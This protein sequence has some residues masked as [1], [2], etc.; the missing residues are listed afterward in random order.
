MRPD[1]TRRHLPRADVLVVKAGRPELLRFHDEEYDL[2]MLDGHSSLDEI[3]EP[4]TEFSRKRSPITT[5][6]NSA[7]CTAAAW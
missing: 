6:C 2:C 3:K 5:F 1:L 4:E 7:C